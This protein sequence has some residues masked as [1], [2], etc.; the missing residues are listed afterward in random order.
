MIKGTTAQFNFKLPCTKAELLWATMTVGQRGNSGTTSAP[1]PIIK[2][3][4]DCSEPDTS[5]KLCFSLNALETMRFSEKMKAYVQFRA[6]RND[7]TVFGNRTKYVSVYPMSDDIL[8][9]DVPMLPESSG[10]DLIVLDAG[11]I[12]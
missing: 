10:E 1:L 6:Q 4:I 8:D 2:R 11:T 12:I 7:G 3:K 5:N 9:Q